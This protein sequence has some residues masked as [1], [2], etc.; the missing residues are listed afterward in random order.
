MIKAKIGD[1]VLLGITD[2]NIKRLIAGQPIKLNLSELGLPDQKI[3]IMY[4]KDEQEIYEQLKPYM[5]KE[6]KINREP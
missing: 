4:G 6:T 2:E 1:S 5:S 3:G